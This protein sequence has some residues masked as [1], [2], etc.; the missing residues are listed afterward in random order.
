M[1]HNKQTLQYGN[2][3][4][5][6]QVFFIPNQKQKVIIDVLPNGTVQVKAPE[7]GKL[8]DIKL[9]VHKRARWIHNHIKKIQQQYAHVLPRQYVSGECH[10]YLGRRHVLKIIKVT[11]EDQHVKLLRGQL[12]VYTDSRQPEIIKGLMFDWYQD[13]AEKVFKR[14]LESLLP[15]THWLKHVP[16]LKL[17]AM[18]KQWGSCSPKGTLSLNPYLVKAPRECVDYVILHE[19]CHL[20]EH[21]HSKKFYVLLSQ[22]MPEWEAIKAKLDGMSELLL[23]E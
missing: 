11:T 14:R 7:S 23:A 19:L 3:A 15:Q 9:A 2:E 12:Q 13:H 20:K 6:Y 4:I 8:K 18:K 10:Y 1:Q 21:N 5:T 22:L 17:R 16:P